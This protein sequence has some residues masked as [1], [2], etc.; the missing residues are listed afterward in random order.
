MQLI[1]VQVEVEK[2]GEEEETPFRFLR[3]EGWIELEE[4]VDRWYQ[5]PGNPE[6]PMA[7]YFKVMGSDLREYLLKRDLEDGEWFLLKRW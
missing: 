2:A 5:G 4:V 6:W 3:K 7:E 1:P